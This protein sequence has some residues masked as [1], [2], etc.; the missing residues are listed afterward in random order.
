MRLYRK[1]LGTG[2]PIDE[3]EN[4]YC[5]VYID[6]KGM[7]R[8]S[9]Q[10]SLAQQW[11]QNMINGSSLKYNIIWPFLFLSAT[12][13]LPLFLLYFSKLMVCRKFR[14]PDDVSNFSAR[15]FTAEENI[16]ISSE[17]MLKTYRDVSGKFKYRSSSFFIIRAYF[18]TIF[19]PVIFLKFVRYVYVFNKGFVNDDV[20]VTAIEYS[21]ASSLISD[22]SAHVGVVVL[23][24]MHGEKGANSRDAFSQFHVFSVWDK[25]YINLFQRLNVSSLFLLSAPN[26]LKIKYC[27]VT[28]RDGLIY[29]LQGLETA[30]DLR[31]IYNKLIYLSGTLSSDL[32]SFKIHPRYNNSEIDKFLI[33]KNVFNGDLSEAFSKYCYIVGDYSTVL[34]QAYVSR[35]LGKDYV[36]VLINGRHSLGMGHIMVS[37]ADFIMV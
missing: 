3:G 12:L 16:S 37:Y 9:I 6:K 22:L 25:H 17:I 29:F 2:A 11:C 34:Y 20:L 14:S 36:I 5:D 28:S 10:R 33:D 23:N 4:L 24:V 35:T 19:S 27:E 30:K 32:I 8:N 1:Y 21:S 31:I 15:F 18:G 13:A 26:K 7:P